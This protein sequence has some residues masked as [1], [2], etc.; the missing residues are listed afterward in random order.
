MPFGEHRLEFANRWQDQNSPIE[1]SYRLALFTIRFRNVENGNFL[2]SGITKDR[3]D[4]V[5]CKPCCIRAK[6]SSS[7]GCLQKYVEPVY[8]G[9]L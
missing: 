2:S 4:L 6:I 3:S 9:S 1:T 5:I 7:A 8:S